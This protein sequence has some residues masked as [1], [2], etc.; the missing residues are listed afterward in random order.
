MSVISVWG[1]AVSLK[2]RCVLKLKNKKQK[3][4]QDWI[5]KKSSSCSRKNVQHGFNNSSARTSGLNDGCQLLY[6]C[7]H[8]QGETFRVML[9]RCSPLEHPSHVRK[10]WQL[11][12]TQERQMNINLHR[13]CDMGILFLQDTVIRT[14][15]FSHYVFMKCFF[16]CLELFLC[17]TLLTHQET[18]K[19]FGCIV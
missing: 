15:H 10:W 4:Q 14:G 1:A 19:R 16:F 18:N 5:H 13:L 17:P 6:V 9:T 11:S 2:K 8:W 3:T 12:E 7:Q